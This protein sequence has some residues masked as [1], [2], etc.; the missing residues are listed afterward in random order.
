MAAITQP[1]ADS[2][3]PLPRKKFTREEVNRLL[4]EG[5]FDGQRFELIDG[6]LIDKMGQNPPHASAIRRLM[7]LL[8]TTFSVERLMVQ[9]PIEAGP[10]DRKWSQPEPDLAVLAA[11]GD[12]SARHPDGH[13]LSLVV[14]VADSSVRHDAN[15][16]R[17]MYANAGV[18]EYWVLDLDARCLLVFRNLQ[19]GA[20]TESL[21]L[22][23]DEL[24]PHIQKP[25]SELL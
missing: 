10:R 13:E 2:G 16:K 21:V 4:E 7:A 8:A 25:I 18:P 23:Q 9:A 17:D 12:Y 6:D 1:L 20:Y 24:V 22:S 11:P 15:R 5:F 14:E 19:D 3:V